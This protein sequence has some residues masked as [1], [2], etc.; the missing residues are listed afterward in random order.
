MNFKNERSKFFL[1]ESFLTQLHSLTSLINPNLKFY[2]SKSF[3]VRFTSSS[4]FATNIRWKCWPEFCPSVGKTS[5]STSPTSTGNTSNIL[6]KSKPCVYRNFVAF[7]IKWF[8]TLFLDVL[9]KITALINEN[10]QET[11]KCWRY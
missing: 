2:S 7:V 11:H 5:S 8:K 1:K 10:Y 4:T 3:R 9:L 6:E